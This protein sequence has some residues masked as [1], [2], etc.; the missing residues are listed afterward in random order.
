[1]KTLLLLSL[2]AFGIHANAQVYE[3]M[4]KDGRV[5]KVVSPSVF[6][7]SPDVSFT[8]SVV[9]DTIV[10]GERCKK[11]LQVCDMDAESMETLPFPK[12]SVLVALE[13]D[14]KVCSYNE[15]TEK[16]MTLMDF[17]MHK[18]DNVGALG[19]ISQEDCIEVGGHRYRRYTMNGGEHNEKA[20]WV[21]GIGASQSFWVES[22]QLP[23]GNYYYE[24][25]L[26]C[27]DNGTLVFTRD[28]FFCDPVTTGITSLT[29]A[30]KADTRMYDILG[31]RVTRPVKGQLYITKG[32]K[33]IV[34]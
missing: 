25:M 23:T 30:E 11:I 17:N 22:S 21:E 32:E 7:H 18:G 8:I 9:G 3:P 10:N 14:G 31:Q 33:H 4:L 20:C 34:K 24:L 15:G 2:L 26:A 5:W 29:E 19:C 16:F 27:Y 28:N 1:M 12:Q 6:S 13:K